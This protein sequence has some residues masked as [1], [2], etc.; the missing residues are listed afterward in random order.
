MHFSNLCLAWN[1]SLFRH[2]FP[3]KS[4]T[5][6]TQEKSRSQQLSIVYPWCSV[7]AINA[8]K[9]NHQHL[10][11]NYAMKTKNIFCGKNA[12]RRWQITSF[13][14]L[15]DHNWKWVS[16]LLDSAHKNIYMRKVS[17][18]NHILKAIQLNAYHWF[19]QI[20]PVFQLPF[21][22]YYRVPM[23]FS[24]VSATHLKMGWLDL[25]IGHWAVLYRLHE[26]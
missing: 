23:S 20:G 5:F 10:I 26:L 8:C 1:G 14:Q 22:S 3:I 12:A 13:T 7:H 2:K 18:F 17:C 11:C 24:H 25:K 4:T 21:L 16:I 15:S 19:L 9:T 6:S